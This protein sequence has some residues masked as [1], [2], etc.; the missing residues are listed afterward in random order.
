MQQ[1]HS[2]TRWICTEIVSSLWG[3]VHKSIISLLV[4]VF[5]YPHNASFVILKEKNFFSTWIFVLICYWRQHLLCWV[6]LRD[7]IQSQLKMFTFWC[8]GDTDHA[9]SSCAYS[10]YVHKWR[11]SVCIEINAVLYYFI[12]FKTFIVRYLYFNA[13]ALPGRLH[14]MCHRVNLKWIIYATNYS[15]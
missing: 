6:A 15:H 4:G 10:T 14:K 8:V 13:L 1:Y 7:Y 12:Y 3:I 9:E 5:P 11:L 2:I